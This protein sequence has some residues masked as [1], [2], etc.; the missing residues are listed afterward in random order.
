MNASVSGI[1][2]VNVIEVEIATKIG[3]RREGDW[4][5][6]TELVA[7]YR[8]NSPRGSEEQFTFLTRKAIVI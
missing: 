1:V 7:Y 2:N 4:I 5:P 8:L 3:I 6:A